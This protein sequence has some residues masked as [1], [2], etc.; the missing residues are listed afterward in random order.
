M[1]L[2]DIDTP[3][4]PGIVNLDPGTQKLMNDSVA[5]SAQ[6]SGDLANETFN[7]AAQLAQKS[8]DANAGVTQAETQHG[9]LMDPNMISA[10]R[11]KY[12]Q[13][14]GKNLTDLSSD[15]SMNAFKQ[16]SERLKFAQNAIIA[17]QKVENANYQRLVDAA[18]NENEIRAGV[19]KSWMGAA[20]MIAGTAIAGPVAGMA[21][22]TAV[23]ASTGGGGKP[24]PL[25]GGPSFSIPEGPT[26]NDYM[27]NY[28]S[29]SGSGRYGGGH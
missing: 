20:G 23:N 10:V 19:L 22:S 3:P 8:Y 2:F 11:S 26:Q 17:K 29:S 6:S 25:G 7:P 18:N 13:M 14:L 12:G 4:K 21:A 5:R 9:G 24:T 16:R 15:T 1:G 28:G 27:G